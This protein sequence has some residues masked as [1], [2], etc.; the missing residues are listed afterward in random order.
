MEAAE[1]QLA[2]AL[3]ALTEREFPLSRGTEQRLDAYLQLEE[4]QRLEDTEVS[5][6]QLQRH[7]A[8]LLSE[9]RFDL[10]HNTLRDVL[11]A[12]L[13]CLSYF[14]HHRSLAASFSD[15]Q[16]TFFLGELIRRLFS[17]LDRNT[18]KLCLWCL[19]MQNFPVERHHFLPHTVEGLV[20]AVV[21]PFKSRAIEVQALKGLHLLLV[22]YP[23]QL[24]VNR[25]VLSIYIRPIASRLSSNDTSTRT[26]ARLVLEE[27]SKHAA[28]WS[29]E[30][31]EMVHDCTEEY[32]LSVMKLHMDRGHQKDAMYLW[33]LTLILL[34]SRLSTCLEKLNQILYVPEKCMKDKDAAVRLMAMHA[35]AGIVDI[36]HDC[37]NWLFNKAVVSLLAWPIKFC[38]EHERLLNVVDAAFLSWQNIVSIAVQDFNFYCKAQQQYVE[39]GQQQFVPEWKFWFGE[40][41]IGPLLTLMTKR[42]YTE[43]SSSIELEL[44]QFID[45]ARRIWKLEVRESGKSKSDPCWS[46]SSSSAIGIGSVVDGCVTTKQQD[47]V[48]GLIPKG[49]Q[50]GDPVCITSELIGI[51]F[52]FEDICKAMSSLIKISDESNNEVSKRYACDL[53][54]TTWMGVCQRV[55]SGRERARGMRREDTSQTSILSLRLA[56]MAIEFSFGILTLRSAS[57]ATPAPSGVAAPTQQSGKNIEDKAV[58]SSSVG[59]G[60]K[61]QLRLLIPLVSDISF[62]GE[63]QAVILH[64]KCKIFDHVTQRMGYLKKEYAQCAMVLEK[65]NSSEGVDGLQIDFSAKSNVLAY[66]VLNLLFEYAIFVDDMQNNYESITES[67]LAS[68]KIVLK[69][70]MLSTKV[71]SHQEVKGLDAVSRYGEEFIR[72]ADELVVSV[73]S[74]RPSMLDELAS[75]CKNLTEHTSESQQNTSLLL[76]LHQP[77]ENSGAVARATASTTSVHSDASDAEEKSAGNAIDQTEYLTASFDATTSSSCLRSGEILTI[78]CARPVEQSPASIIDEQPKLQRDSQLAPYQS[79]DESCDPKGAVT[80]PQKSGDYGQKDAESPSM[81]ASLMRP[82]EPQLASPKLTAEGARHLNLIASQCIYPDLVEC[83]EQI[84]SLYRHVPISFRPFF[85]FYK[86]RTIGDL[87]ALP[88]EKVK[89]FG[90]KEPVNIVRRA[91]DDFNERKVRMKSLAGSPFRQRCV[92]ATASPAISTPSPHKSSKRP[93]LVDGGAISPLTIE[94]REHKRAKRS[95]VLKNAEDGEEKQESE[96]THRKPE[97]IDKVT[98]CLRSGDTGKIQITRHGHDD[99]LSQMKPSDKIDTKKHVQEKMD[100]YTLQLLQHLRRSAYYMDKLVA[101]EVSIQSGEESLQ[102]N[103][104]T[105]SDVI[106]NYHEAHDLVARLASQLQ[107]AAETSSK[108][109]RKL[110]AKYAPT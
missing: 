65:W 28:K 24:G 12:A 76:D 79:S 62:S 74:K 20:Q 75:V 22:K 80:T 106:T 36:F 67:M 7:L 68:M 91:L 97:L 2:R 44:K 42:I 55:L 109:C 66:L 105:A 72:V 32:V 81:K 70:L 58:V 8:P 110:L 77:C 30:T 40:L 33:K 38:L 27:A 59:F 100:S 83:T 53:A 86:I 6:L 89:T 48:C 103:I 71:G 57:A 88:V 63:L 26:Q 13:C 35:W 37:Q 61:W 104:A 5:V 19:I 46:G 3:A 43:D 10:Q 99:S 85:S 39:A 41:V 60:V 51:A 1:T 18:Y 98:L 87:S 34:R 107:I 73:E 101:E 69:N 50:T 54:M 9:L 49:G 11:H 93:F 17:T 56:R 47:N 82:F 95:L 31:L 52:L 78:P 25:T 15:D 108:R 16:V 102:T 45:F 96:G 29:Q 14:M 84:A 94:T 4:L 92:S 23:E 21:N 90:L 64:P